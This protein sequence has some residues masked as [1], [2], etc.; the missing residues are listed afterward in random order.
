MRSPSPRFPRSPLSTSL[1]QPGRVTR[2]RIR[3]IVR[4]PKLRRPPAVLLVLAALAVLLCGDLVL[5]QP[6]QAEDALP[7][8]SAGTQAPDPAPA[9]APDGAPQDSAAPITPAGLIASTTLTVSGSRV[10]TVDLYG[11][12]VRPDD[13][14]WAARYAVEEIQV[15][16]DC[17]WVQTIRTAELTYAYDG[18]YLFD[19]LFF[20]LIGLLDG[21]DTRDL[22]FDGAQDLGLLAAESYPQNVPYCYLLWDEAAGRFST[23]P[24]MLFAPVELDQDAKQVIEFE[25]D[26]AALHYTNYYGYDGSG[27]LT[28]LHRERVAAAD[29]VR[30]AY[31]SVLEDIYTDGLYPD[32]NMMP[33]E[34]SY[35]DFAVVDLD[36]DSWEELL[37]QYTGAPVAARHTYVYGYDPA[38]GQLFEKLMEYPDLE[39]Y[40]N[41]AV[42]AYSS[43]NQG[44]AGRFW[45][46]SVYR[47]DAGTGRYEMAGFANA[48]DRE[49]LAAADPALPS[50][51][52]DA[53]RDGDG[54]VYYLTE[55]PYGEADPVDG[56]EYEAWRDGWLSGAS[57]LELRWEALS[58]E[59]IRMVTAA[60]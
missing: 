6:A 25:K 3:R 26:G 16:E 17:E 23:D 50:F 28:L 13:P 47:Y 58:P 27:S 59:N 19:G 48:L 43:H 44:H 34:I 52:Y 14:D 57:Q 35:M 20:D 33:P 7:G 39:F 12:S 38:T 1:A 42:V 41:G 60:G 45:P 15:F 5:F 21:I 56:A 24:I 40:D 30:A 55:E 46:Y 18:P 32:G 49:T 53:D 51:P 22:N 29:P 36:G 37:V 31:R 4:F 11:A 54:L 8:P 10:L 9:R 2:Q